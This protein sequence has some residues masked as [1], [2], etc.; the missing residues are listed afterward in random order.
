M[1]SKVI[2]NNKKKT[3][4]HIFLLSIAFCTWC[5]NVTQKKFQSKRFLVPQLGKKK[6]K[7]V[8]LISEFDKHVKNYKNKFYVILIYEMNRHTRQV[9]LK[10]SVPMV[11]SQLGAEINQITTLATL[12]KYIFTAHQI[13]HILSKSLYAVKNN[14][15]RG[16]FLLTHCSDIRW[17]YVRE[18]RQD[19]CCFCLELNNR[20]ILTS[21]VFF[22]VMIT[23]MHKLSPHT[24]K[25]LLIVF[26][27]NFFFFILEQMVS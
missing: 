12:L 9:N 26:G 2:N 17:V 18:R 20:S 22:W 7:K 5:S 23:C 3:F 16:L 19:E 25:L 24:S 6:K 21:E 13:R 14:A 11:K 27:S 1:G 4:I 15:K 8:Q 10:N